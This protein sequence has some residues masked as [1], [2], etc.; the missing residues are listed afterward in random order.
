VNKIILHEADHFSMLPHDG[1]WRLEEW[2]Q[3]KEIIRQN[4]GALDSA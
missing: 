4:I 1:H 3:I 2:Q